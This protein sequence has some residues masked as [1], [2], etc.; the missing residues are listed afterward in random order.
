MYSARKLM[1]ISG[2]GNTPNLSITCAANLLR[3]VNGECRQILAKCS[4]LL[5]KLNT[6][7]YDPRTILSFVSIVNIPKEAETDAC[8]P[9]CY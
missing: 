4:E 3:A 9:T 8:H 6:Y 7:I 5:F 2:S 1:P